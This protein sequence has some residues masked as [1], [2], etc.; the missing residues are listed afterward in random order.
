VRHSFAAEAQRRWADEVGLLVNGGQA[1]GE[2]DPEDSGW[3]VGR[4]RFYGVLACLFLI[5]SALAVYSYNVEYSM[6]RR[7]YSDPH[8]F[9]DVYR[10][11]DVTVQS[12][13]IAPFGPPFGLLP[14]W[15]FH[16]TVRATID[17]TPAR[18]HATATYWRGTANFESLQ[19]ERL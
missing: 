17:G 13:G 11:K 3:K 1:G 16:V 6:T 19:R 9:A 2:M 7:F 5:W 14:A 10:S 12:I 15:G 8:N 18:G 4:N